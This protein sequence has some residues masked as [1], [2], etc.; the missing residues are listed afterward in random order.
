MSPP[1]SSFKTI[2]SSEP[3]VAEGK[4]ERIGLRKAPPT[5]ETASP[6][7][8]HETL[9]ALQRREDRPRPEM[10]IALLEAQSRSV[11]S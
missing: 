7:D 9:W 8:H 10:A 4:S 11:R 5:P 6:R 1:R 2:R 3:G